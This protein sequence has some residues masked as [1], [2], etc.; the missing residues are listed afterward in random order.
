[1]SYPDQSFL[2]HLRDKL[3]TIMDASVAFTRGGDDLSVRAEARTPRMSQ[4][5][6][7]AHPSED[8]QARRPP[9]RDDDGDNNDDP[10]DAGSSPRDTHG[11]TTSSST[12][13]AHAGRKRPAVAHDDD[14]RESSRRKVARPSPGV[15]GIHAD[16]P[17]EELLDYINVLLQREGAR[18]VAAR[19]HRRHKSPV[20]PGHEATAEQISSSIVGTLGGARSRRG[21]PTSLFNITIANEMGTQRSLL[22]AGSAAAS[23]EEAA[24][25]AA[26]AAQSHRAKP[27]ACETAGAGICMFS[28]VEAGIA[29]ALDRAVA[30]AVEV[31]SQQG[32]AAATAAE[33]RVKHLVAAAVEAAT[34]QMAATIEGA[35]ERAVA[36]ALKAALQPGAAQPSQQPARAPSSAPTPSASAASEGSRAVAAAA[37]VG[38]DWRDFE[39]EMESWWRSCLVCR[40]KGSSH[41]HNHRRESAAC[42]LRGTAEGEAFSRALSGLKDGLFAG[43]R[44]QKYSCCFLCGLPQRVCE[45]WEARLPRRDMYVRAPGGECQHPFLGMDLLAALI[46]FQ[47]RRL[48][49]AMLDAGLVWRESGSGSGRRARRVDFDEDEVLVF[50]A[51]KVKWGELEMMRGLRIAYTVCKLL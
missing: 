28:R 18:Q 36:K 44:I 17:R 27:C 2:G 14:P 48:G 26:A 5:S 15:H 50:M 20:S 31:S 19:G 30:R 47:P 4:D 35:V 46:A 16:T 11:A 22:Q 34:R 12:V 43:G 37:A 24:A 21:S 45:R 41:A 38:E 6:R 40:A 33:E 9:V 8:E 51:K 29:N 42:P 32:L 49:E 3:A 23:V 13:H 7:D 25:A 39:R 1:M 10:T